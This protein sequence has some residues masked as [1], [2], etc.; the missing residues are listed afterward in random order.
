MFQGLAQC[1]SLIVI[2]C[3]DMFMSMNQPPA[4]ADPKDVFER[5]CK[6]VD[7]HL[8][9]LESIL[10]LGKI[11]SIGPQKEDSKGVEGFLQ[12][13]ADMLALLRAGSADLAPEQLNE[14][15]SL[16]ARYAVLEDLVQRKTSTR[17]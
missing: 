6:I 5:T 3:Y 14:V 7:D 16:G 17:L 8:R 1:A 11:D 12:E 10:V 2:S 13:S 15:A 4:P 9:L